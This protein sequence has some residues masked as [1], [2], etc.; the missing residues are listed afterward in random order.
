VE[1]LTLFHA[2]GSVEVACNLLNVHTGT[3][4]EEVI[5]N[6]RLAAEE[7]GLTIEDIYTTAPTEQELLNRI[8]EL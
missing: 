4:A 1:A 6:A 7:L 2:E 5:S 3:S 8:K